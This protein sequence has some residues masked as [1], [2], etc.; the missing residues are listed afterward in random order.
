MAIMMNEYLNRDKEVILPSYF[1]LN[2]NPKKETEIV[3]VYKQIL[4]QQFDD[5]RSEFQ[6]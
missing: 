6:S 1:C 5:S 4:N 3:F 2:K